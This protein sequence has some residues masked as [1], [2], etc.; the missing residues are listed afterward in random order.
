MLPENEP[1]MRESERLVMERLNPKSIDPIGFKW[2]DF[3]AFCRVQTD[4]TTMRLDEQNDQ[5]GTDIGRARIAAVPK[6]KLDDIETRFSE[7]LSA[8]TTIE[9]VDAAISNRLA[10]I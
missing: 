1:Y 7:S 8:A 2:E 6:E 4:L 5:W 10:A 3:T 9:E